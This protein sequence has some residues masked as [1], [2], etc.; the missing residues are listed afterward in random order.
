VAYFGWPSQPGG[1]DQPFQGDG[2]AGRDVAVVVGALAGGQVAADEQPVPRAGGGDPGPGVVP[3]AFRSAPGRGQHPAPPGT[4][5]RGDHIGAGEPAAAESEDERLGD[6]QHIPPVVVFEVAAQGGTAAVYL[7]AAHEVGHHAVGAGVGK[8]LDRQLTL[9]GERQVFRQP[10]PPPHGGVFEVL[11]RDPLPEPD[12]PV[13]SVLADIGQVHGV[14]PI[15]DPAGTA[16]VLAFDPRTGGAGFLLAGL[17]HRRDPQP[18]PPGRSIQATD[19]KPPDHA[20]RRPGV[21]AGMV[22]QPLS[23]IR[24]GIPHPLRDAPAVA[25]TQVRQARPDILARL[26]PRFHPHKAAPD[27]VSQLAEQ[28][29]GPAGLYHEGSSRPWSCSRHTG[30]IMR[31]LRLR[32]PIP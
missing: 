22:E 15:G 32:P 28:V 4:Q 6:P 24:G 17:I 13:P 2:L 19:D 1:G 5:M 25:F 20:H 30:R 8:D 14:D 27:A 10:H 16:H 21:P 11:T 26:N 29:T 31:R 7:I 9:G 3:F 23:L 12:Q 18:A